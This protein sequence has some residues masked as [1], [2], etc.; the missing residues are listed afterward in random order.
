MNWYAFFLA[1]ANIGIRFLSK[2]QLANKFITKNIP[3]PRNRIVETARLRGS[4]IF[5][6]WQVSTI[7]PVEQ[8]TLTRYW[9]EEHNA[10]NLHYDI[11]IQ[12]QDGRYYRWATSNPKWDKF[13]LRTWV[14]QPEHYKP[15]NPAIIKEGYG[16]GTSKV[17]DKGRAL[18]WTE[19]DHLHIKFENKKGVWV[20]LGDN[21]MVRANP[22]DIPNS[23]KGHYKQITWDQA[24]GYTN[25]PA[26]L[27]SV[28]KDGAQSNW[29]LDIDPRTGKNTFSI[30]SHR[31]DKRLAKQTGKTAQI[32][33]TPKLKDRV[34]QIENGLD[35]KRLSQ[36]IG[37]YRGKTIIEGKAEVW[38][39]DFYELNQCLQPND[40]KA[41]AAARDPW[42]YG[43]QVTK[44]N[45]KDVASL[46]YSEKLVILEAIHDANPHGPFKVPP[47][48][49][50]RLGKTALI[51]RAKAEDGVD[52]V[53][54]QRL[55][56]N[57]TLKAKFRTDSEG[58]IVGFQQEQTTTGTEKQ[59]VIPIVRWH[60]KELPVA[61]EHSADIKT[62]MYNNPDQYLGETL[63]FDYTRLTSNGVPF[64]PIARGIKLD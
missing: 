11:T 18:I 7:T 57:E 41:F 55:D 46:P 4:P 60:G 61:G 56:G 16:A 52:G 54:F 27:A 37:T 6:S 5:P 9:I 44:V 49:T 64:Q 10:T 17:V 34:S 20:Y 51:A 62:D 45:G 35:G 63:A 39:D 30:G 28:K 50:T 40:V 8:P 47:Y 58:K 14:L 3:A 2:R 22:R 29:R 43:F 23:P 19:N 53:V 13:G 33:W 59:S 26:Y 31:Q 25:D 32:D 42:I 38:V 21:K 24:K 12:A 48:A 36:R 15:T 1:T